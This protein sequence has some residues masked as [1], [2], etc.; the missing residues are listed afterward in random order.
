[1]STNEAEQQNSSKVIFK[2]KNQLNSNKVILHSNLLEQKI[3]R[4]LEH[5]LESDVAKSLCVDLFL[6]QVTMND[7]RIIQEYLTRFMDLQEG[8]KFFEEE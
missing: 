5:E 7:R 1:M 3:K 2:S 8:L 4:K 6:N